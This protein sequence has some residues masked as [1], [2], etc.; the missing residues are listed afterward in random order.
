MASASAAAARITALFFPSARFTAASRSASD[1]KTVARF[2]RSAS[3]CISIACLMPGGGR[4]SRISYRRHSRP[5]AVA[6]SLMV[7][8]MRELRWSRSSK[9]LS[10]EI[11]PI[12]LRIVVCASCETAYIGFSTP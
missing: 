3:A 5:H 8:T 6:A 4:M 1:S 7:A 10:S 12:S 9:V 2:R 11:F